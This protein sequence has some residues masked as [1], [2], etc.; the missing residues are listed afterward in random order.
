MAEGDKHN[1]IKR[2][3]S[4]VIVIVVFVAI[5]ELLK[6]IMELKNEILPEDLQPW[7]ALCSLPMTSAF[8]HFLS[9]EI[10]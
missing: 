7:C 1:A 10:L 9:A 5:L 8:P 6:V 3:I 4:V 2:R